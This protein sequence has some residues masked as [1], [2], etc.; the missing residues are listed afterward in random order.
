MKIR[1]AIFCSRRLRL[2]EWP[3]AF[4]HFNR[5]PPH[6]E[7]A[8][9]QDARQLIQNWPAILLRPLLFIGENEQQINTANDVIV[10]G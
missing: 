4:E 7:I 2:F 10:F 1:R 9:T 8:R 5:Y 6:A 3:R